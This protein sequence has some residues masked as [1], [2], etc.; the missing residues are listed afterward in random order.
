L[1]VG[2]EEAG[3]DGDGDGDGGDARGRG[4]MQ[5]DESGDILEVYKPY[6]CVY[7]CVYIYIYI[8]IYIEV[9]QWYTSWRYNYL[10]VHYVPTQYGPR[11]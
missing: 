10:Q 11:R 2:E 8:Y 9:Y 3:D 4:V 7:M 1:A 5:S 6:T